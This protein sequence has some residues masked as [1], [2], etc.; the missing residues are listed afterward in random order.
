MAKKVRSP[1]ARPHILVTGF[2]PF[3]GVPYNASNALV[4]FLDDAARDL[5]LR[6]ETALLP[7]D[8]REGPAKATHCAETL[9]PD[10]IIH[11]GVS[12]RAKAFQLEMCA[13]N[14]CRASADCSGRPPEGFHVQRGGPPVL[15]STF[16]A[17]FL[18]RRLRYL[19]IPAYLSFNAGRYLCNATLYRSL[20]RASQLPGADAPLIG[21]I[22]IPAFAADEIEA[23]TTNFGWRALKNGAVEILRAMAFHLGTP[24]HSA[25]RHAVN[26]IKRSADHTWRSTV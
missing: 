1:I 5:P 4:G 26:R 19:R 22:H 20:Y 9:R 18:V 13:F 6:L 21:F 7:T 25:G 14:H 8:W 24:G 3:P 2:G 17:E 15:H 16:P 10:A 12:S 11:F 23:G